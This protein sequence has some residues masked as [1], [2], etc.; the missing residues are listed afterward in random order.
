MHEVILV[1]K[2]KL[3]WEAIGYYPF[4]EMFWIKCQIQINILTYNTNKHINLVFG[5]SDQK[6]SVMA[7]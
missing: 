6:R 3:S 7:F 5:T 4:Q 1:T 2:V